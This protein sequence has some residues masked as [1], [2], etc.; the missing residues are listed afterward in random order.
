MEPIISPWAV[1]WIC[2]L[3]NIQ[4]LFGAIVAACVIVSIASLVIADDAG[5]EVDISWPRAVKRVKKLAVVGVISLLIA[6]MMPTKE[7]VLSM[8]A[9]RHITPDNITKAVQ[10]GADWKETLKADVID[11][12][13][14][15]QDGKKKGE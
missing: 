5:E 11:I 15:V 1:Y 2:M 12:L 13:E 10:V 8:I 7:I 14:G 4:G 3:S 9:A 6:T